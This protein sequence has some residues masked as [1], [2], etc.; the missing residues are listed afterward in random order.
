MVKTCHSKYSSEE[1]VIRDLRNSTIPT[2]VVFENPPEVPQPNKAVERE[3]VLKARPVEYYHEFQKMILQKQDTNSSSV[4]DEA[5]KTSES[6]PNEAQRKTQVPTRQ[7]SSQRIVEE[8][9][10]ALNQYDF[11]P[12]PQLNEIVEPIDLSKAS[13]ISNEVFQP[14]EFPEEI[15]IPGAN[16]Q[17]EIQF[18]S[19]APGETNP[20]PS[21]RGSMEFHPFPATDNV[22]IQNITPVEIPTQPLPPVDDVIQEQATAI[23]I[24]ALPKLPSHNVKHTNVGQK[25]TTSKRILLRA[26]PKMKDGASD[27]ELPKIESQSK[28]QFRF[29][30]GN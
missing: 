30:P 20:E 17:A 15:A 10:D 21:Q 7:V 9:R 19:L 8:Q 1:E 18:H 13:S 12:L 25:A 3:I 23:K 11:R 2:K 4:H 24:S 16:Q 6:L 26:V 29:I 27:V 5:R 22:P 14:Y 28:A